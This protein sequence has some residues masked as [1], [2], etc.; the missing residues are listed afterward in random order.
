MQIRMLITVVIVVV[1]EQ[2]KGSCKMNLLKKSP[3]RT[4]LFVL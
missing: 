3:E 2:S 1:L 4:V